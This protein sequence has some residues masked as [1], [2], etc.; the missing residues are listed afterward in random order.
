MAIYKNIRGKEKIQHNNQ[1][2]TYTLIVQGNCELEYDLANGDY[3][4]LI[5]QDEGS[6]INFIEKGT[7]QNARVDMVYVGINQ[8]NTIQNSSFTLKHRGEIEVT[9]YY[10]VP[11]RKEKKISFTL[12]NVEGDSSAN[13]ENY[14]VCV[15]EAY[16]TVD[17]E[18]QI[19]KGAKR[20]KSHQHSR[21]LTIGKPKH[22]KVAPIL[23]IYEND[24]EAG[25]GLSTGTIDESIL[26][27]MKSRGLSRKEALILLI[28][29]YLLPDLDKFKDYEN[30]QEI[31][32]NIEEKVDRLCSM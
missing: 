20:S 7:I 24:V 12:R 21:C 25:H 29:A 30:A 5:I 27:Y 2:E 8:E 4:F 28:R 6:S 23:K 9:S 19:D 11:E 26:Y 1:N 14:G 18:G 3:R 16:L 32:R 17:V 13:I 15:D 31:L 10:L 22:V